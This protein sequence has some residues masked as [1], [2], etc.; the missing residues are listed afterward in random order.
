MTPTTASQ[1]VALT[2]ERLLKAAAKVFARDGLTGATTR[3][4]AR[5]AEVNEV[6][7][8]RHF[9][10]KEELISAVV[11]QTFETFPNRSTRRKSHEQADSDAPAGLE[12]LR[13]LL[14]RFVEDYHALLSKHLPLIRTLI[15][16]IHR[17]E[18]EE[19]CVLHG[20]FRPKRRELIEGLKAEQARCGIRAD[21]DVTIV[22]DQLGGM[23]FGHVIRQ[24]SPLPVEYGA[25]KYLEGCVELV[26]RSIERSIPESIGRK[27]RPRGTARKRGS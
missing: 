16:E 5:M 3:E 12:S 18:N 22:A 7:L 8:F 6:T 24:A 13:E 4:I 9:H 11:N 17:H 15:G 1:R 14:T 23:I 20:V 27:H 10:S 26:A 19:M 2:R 21:V 25:A